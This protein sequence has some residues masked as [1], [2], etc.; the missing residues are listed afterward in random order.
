MQKAL[1]AAREAWEALAKGPQGDGDAAQA[2]GLALTAAS[3]AEQA[4]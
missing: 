4:G 3:R 1:D 2:V